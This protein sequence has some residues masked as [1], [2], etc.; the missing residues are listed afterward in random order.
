MVSELILGI[1]VALYASQGH[2]G[3]VVREQRIEPGDYRLIAVLQAGPAK[4]NVFDLRLYLD[5]SADGKTWRRR[6]ACTEERDLYA[7]S[8]APVHFSCGAEL[9]D[10]R[11]Y[12]RVEIRTGQCPVI[13]AVTLEKMR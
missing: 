10:L 3:T 9:K 11:E 4:Q 8:P 6:I 2:L 7:S 12:V 13:A 5:D 1:F